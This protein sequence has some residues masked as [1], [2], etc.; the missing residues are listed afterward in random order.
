MPNVK[1]PLGG[2]YNQSDW[3][4]QNNN[5]SYD[6]GQK[7]E[8]ESTNCTSVRSKVLRT[9]QDKLTITFFSKRSVLNLHNTFFTLIDAQQQKKTNFP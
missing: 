7:R 1:M 5:L 2:V 6:I 3:N 9:L 8:K 4:N